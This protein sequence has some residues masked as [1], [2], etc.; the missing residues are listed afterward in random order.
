MRNRIWTGILAAVSILCGVAGACS[1][2]GEK[3]NSS[4]PGGDTGDYTEGA[5]PGAGGSANG[6]VGFFQ[7]ATPCGTCVENHC[8]TALSECG[9]AQ[10]CPE[11]LM[12]NPATCA[13]NQ[14]LL[15]KLV[16]C[17]KSECDAECK[18]AAP[19]PPPNPVCDA[20]ATAPSQGA[21]L[22][23]GQK[24][25]CNPVTNAGCDSTKGEACDLGQ[26]G[27]QCFPGPNTAALCEECGKDKG[28]C[29]GGLFCV[30]KCAKYCCDDT[31]CGSG[32][33]DKSII[34]DPDLPI[35]VCVQR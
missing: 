3:T 2:T 19:P 20:A 8:C 29:A 12:G 14:A 7:N 22:K 13:A 28:Y 25:A 34:R 24:A 26:S 23:L 17:T 15:D 5:V 9:K 33:C 35:G 32:K 31:D 27:F 1:S 16:A 10:G 18:A 21:C 11:C 6:C 30:G 4:A